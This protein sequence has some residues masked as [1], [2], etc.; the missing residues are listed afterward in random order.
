MKK[1]LSWKMAGGAWLLLGVA[2]LVGQGATPI[3]PPRITHDPVGVALRGQPITVLAQ[4][5]A[6]APIKSVTLHYTLSKD[7]SPFKL[8]MQATGPAMF[9]GTIPAGL[10]GNADKVS[11]YIEALDD[12]DA[13]AETP[14]YMVAIK[15]SGALTKG[16]SSA[17]VAAPA[18]SASAPASDKDKTSLVGAGLVAGG[19][20]AVIGAA[21]YIANRNG[22]GSGGGGAVTNVQ[23][24][25]TG[26]K[27]V[28]LS[29]PGQAI[30]CA[31]TPVTIIV[32]QNGDIFSDSLM[33][34]RVISGALSG[35]SFTVGGSTSTSN[36]VSTLSFNGSVVDNRIVGTVSGSAQSATNSGS[37]SGS[38]TAGK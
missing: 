20:A 4:V 27:T 25:Y 21:L 29:I 15:D 35:N 8:A 38:F 11:Y 34:G 24:T 3:E 13:S 28:C 2:W 33:D 1:R 18:A 26:S 32:D 7:A 37:Y 5:S 17:A 36:L 31:T 12:R 30:S 23:G 22:S 19:A 9:L 14:W 6:A 16:A 10:L